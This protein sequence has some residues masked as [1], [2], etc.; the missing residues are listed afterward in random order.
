[1]YNLDKCTTGDFS[2]NGDSLIS[3]HRNGSIAIWDLKTQQI[4]YLHAPQIDK[5]EIELVKYI[6]DTTILVSDKSGNVYILE[7]STNFFSRNLQG[8][9]SFVTTNEQHPFVSFSFLKPYNDKFVKR[10]GER[11]IVAIGCAEKIIIL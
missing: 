1:M 6:Y 5:A 8:D 9:V 11:K 4:L 7:I 10:M 2:Q 3:G